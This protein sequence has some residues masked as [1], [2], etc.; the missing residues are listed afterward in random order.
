MMKAV[1]ERHT[2]TCEIQ[3]A[4]GLS[5]NLVFGQ[6]KYGCDHPWMTDKILSGD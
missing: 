1:C 6:N 2:G 4:K 3:V 5:L